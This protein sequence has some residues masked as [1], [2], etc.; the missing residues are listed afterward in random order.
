VSV[1]RGEGECAVGRRRHLDRALGGILAA[2]GDVGPAVGVRGRDTVRIGPLRAFGRGLVAVAAVGRVI[3][4]AVVRGGRPGSAL[5]ADVAAATGCRCDLELVG[6]AHEDRADAACDHQLALAPIRRRDLHP[7]LV[8]RDRRAFGIDGD[9]EHRPL[10]ERDQIGRA[11]AEMRRVLLL[12]A[13]HRLPEILEHLDNAALLARAGQPQPRRRRDDHIIL[14]AHEHG[15][16][17]GRRF[18]DVAGAERGTALHLAK[19]GAVADLDLAGRL[20]DAPQ[21][22]RRSGG[23]RGE[24]EGGNGES[25][26]QRHGYRTTCLRAPRATPAP[27]VAA[28][29]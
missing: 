7:A 5:A 21:P 22:V 11:D 19:R 3:V 16:S 15:A 9:G 10:H 4:A 26:A 8:D 29:R 27:I 12:D 1:R 17:A 18:D 28:L 24:E 6:V 25:A 14:A 13:E 23:G 20:G 2:I